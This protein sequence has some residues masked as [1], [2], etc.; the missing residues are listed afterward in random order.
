MSCDKQ[1]ENYPKIQFNFF[2]QEIS[3]TFSTLVL[4]AK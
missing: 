3:N 1:N 4:S 2:F